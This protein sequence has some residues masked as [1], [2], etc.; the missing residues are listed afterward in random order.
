MLK[1]HCQ[2]CGR[3]VEVERNAKLIVPTEL[4]VALAGTRG[5]KADL[6][7]RCLGELR[8]RYFGVERSPLAEE[9]A[10]ALA[11]TGPPAFPDFLEE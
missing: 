11:L 2:G 10:Q 1:I 9:H 6:C 8:V 5:E 7:V 4:T 3:A